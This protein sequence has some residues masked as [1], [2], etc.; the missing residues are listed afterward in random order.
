MAEYK[1][2][3]C[4]TTKESEE[5]CSCPICGYRMFE[6]P[7]DRR[8]VLISEIRSFVY[9]LEVR[10]L[11]REDLVF[12]GKAIDEHRFPDYDKILKYVSNSHRTEEFLDNLLETA[13]Q[14]KLHFA[15][16]YSKTYPVSFEILDER[17]KHY[18]EA[19]E[20]VS[21]TLAPGTGVELN[22]VSW[23][24]VSL[25]YSEN[26]NKYLWSSAFELIELVETLAKKIAKFIKTNNLYGNGYRYYP[27]KNDRFIANG[28]YKDELENAIINTESII[29]KKYVVDIMDDGSDELKEMLTCLWNDIELVMDAPLFIKI[30]DYLTETGCIS[31]KELI[32]RYSLVLFD[33]YKEYNTIVDISSLLNNKTEDE[34][35]TSIIKKCSLE[36]KEYEIPKYI[37]FIPEIDYPFSA[38]SKRRAESVKVIITVID[39]VIRKL[40]IKF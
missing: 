7:Y 3:S 5:P 34:I 12:E 1:C 13:E 23:E 11:T 35:R 38:A 27:P 30:Y 25:L 20:V 2:I 32:D 31:E 22:P 6:T 4:G 37:H 16:G 8:N 33:R 14:L 10:T 18:D 29:R 19:L 9:R 39:I 21:K 28:E 36:L 15:E 24:K 17:M 26:Q 40:R